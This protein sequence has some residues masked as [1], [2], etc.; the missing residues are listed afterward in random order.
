MNYSYPTTT[1]RKG[2]YN[3]WREFFTVDA[4]FDFVPAAHVDELEDK[5]LIQ[6][7][8]PGVAKEDV[9]IRLESRILEVKGERKG[10]GKFQKSFSLPDGIQVDAIKAE[11]KDGVLTINIP[12]TELAKAREIAIV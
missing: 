4:A 7:D 5:F 1:M 9:K 11:H 2:L 8:V 10:Y 3:P 12:K 6:V